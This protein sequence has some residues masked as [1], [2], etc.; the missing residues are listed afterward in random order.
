MQLNNGATVQPYVRAA[1]AHEFSKNNEV[2]VNNNV[3][4][5]DLS[6]SRAELGAGI[7]VNLSQRW[8]AHAEVEYMNG[9]GIEMPLGG[10][11]GL[12]FKW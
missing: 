6:G 1:W 7:A 5:N 11:V 12:Q 4:N 9:K 8:Q 10:T 2:K 3:F